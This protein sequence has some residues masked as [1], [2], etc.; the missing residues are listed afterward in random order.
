MA[1]KN[2]SQAS[3]QELLEI[4]ELRKQHN[5]NRATFAGV[6]SANG[7]KPGK[8]VTRGEFTAAVKKF[9]EAPIDGRPRV[10]KE[11]DK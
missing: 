4:G 5:I 6:C 2:Q 3:A 8:Q 9:A 11:A 7:W 10:K 1:A